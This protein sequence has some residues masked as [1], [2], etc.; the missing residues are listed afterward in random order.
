MKTS[1]AIIMYCVGFA[2][3]IGGLFNH[4]VLVMGWALFCMLGIIGLVFNIE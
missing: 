3:A 2:F 4:A 1:F